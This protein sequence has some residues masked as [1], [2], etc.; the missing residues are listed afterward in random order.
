MMGEEQGVLGAWCVLIHLI[1]TNAFGI[2]NKKKNYY[3]HLTGEE[4]EAHSSEKT[5]PNHTSGK[6]QTRLR[7]L[8]E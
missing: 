8:G 1:L 5:C 3:F 2:S 6:R 4:T 7:G